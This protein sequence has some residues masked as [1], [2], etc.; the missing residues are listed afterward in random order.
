[1]TAKCAQK[2]A[3][4]KR[5]LIYNILT[6]NEVKKKLN[7]KQYPFKTLSVNFETNTRMRKH[8]Y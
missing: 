1:M 8:F 6:Q 3:E 5:T 7:T 2:I 4:I